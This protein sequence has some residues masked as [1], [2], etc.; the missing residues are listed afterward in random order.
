MTHPLTGIEDAGLRIAGAFELDADEAATL[1]GQPRMLVLLGSTAGLFWS[2]FERW[3][4]HSRGEPSDNPLDSFTRALVAP[5]A[6]ALGAEVVYPS[7]GPPFWPFQRWAARAEPVFVSPLKI[8]IHPELGL[9]HAY[10][11]ALLFDAPFELPD[12][13][14]AADTQS[15]C[16]TCVRQPCLSA[17]PVSAYDAAG[18]DVDRCAAHV[19]A[20]NDCA[21][22]GCHARRACPVGTQH[23]YDRGQQQ[24][25]L[26]AFLRGRAGAGPRG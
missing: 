19:V 25:H 1:P 15:P 6:T 21:S 9:W 2:H 22:K 12:V 18:Y 20:N 26:R 8:L 4:A 16:V 7:D 13:N 24:F 3:Q 23:E 10:R 11:A 14:A 5:L 17:C